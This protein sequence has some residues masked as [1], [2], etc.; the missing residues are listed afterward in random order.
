MKTSQNGIDLIKRFEGVFLS[1]YLCPAGKPTIGIGSC[2]YENGSKVKMTDNP[3]TEEQAFKLLANT[4][5]NYEAIVKGSLKVPVNQNQFDSLVSHTY[6]TGGSKTLFTMINQG[7]S[8]EMIRNWFETKYTT[9]NGKLLPG[10][11]KRRK[12]EADLYF[13][14]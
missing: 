3:I 8:N 14:K 2:Y 7:S 11:V 13:K 10:L 12:A 6:N 9:G 5:V 1:P 4:L